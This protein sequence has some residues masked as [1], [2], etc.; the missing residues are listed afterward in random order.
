MYHI[1]QG[2]RYYQEL[3]HDYRDKLQPHR[4]MRYLVKRLVA[5]GHE[6]ILVPIDRAVS[7]GVFSEQFIMTAGD[8]AGASPSRPLDTGHGIGLVR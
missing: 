4:L 7:P 1:L 3:G 8:G 5:L 2:D 6:T